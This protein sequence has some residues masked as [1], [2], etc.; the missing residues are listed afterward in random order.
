[1]TSVQNTRAKITT[2]EQQPQRPGTE[3][4]GRNIPPTLAKPITVHRNNEFYFDQF[5]ALAAKN[6][7]RILWLTLPEPELF[8]RRFPGPE[9]AKDYAPFVERMRA[10]HANL[11]VLSAEI[12]SLPDDH[13][14]DVWHLNRYGAWVFSEQAA[15]QLGAWLQQHPL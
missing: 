15:E 7:I 1:V 11:F 6:N 9:R 3:L 2:A 4:D 10:K 5:C 12:P 8:R 14:M 13:Y